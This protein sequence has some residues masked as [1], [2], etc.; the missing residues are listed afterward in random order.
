MKLKYYVVEYIDYLHNDKGLPTSELD[1]RTFRRRQFASKKEAKRFIKAFL[2]ED[3]EYTGMWLARISL[4]KI[5]EKVKLKTFLS[6]GFPDG[7]ASFSFR[8]REAI[9]SERE[10]MDELE[11]PEDLD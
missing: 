1:D 5:T 8:P 10:E 4:H 2:A 7:T 11:N 9:I 3:P 6:R